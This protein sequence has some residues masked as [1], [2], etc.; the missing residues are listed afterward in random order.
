MNHSACR[1]FLAFTLVFALSVQ[2]FAQYKNG[3]EKERM[4]TSCKP[5]DDFYKYINGTWLKNTPIPD[6]EPR[7]GSFNILNDNNRKVLKEILEAAA[8]NKKSKPGSNEQMIGSMYA[9]CMD[10]AV[11]EKQGYKPIQPLLTRI[12]KINDV[13]NLPTEISYLHSVGVPALFN[14]GAQPDAKNSTTNLAGISQ[15][16]LT[17]PNKEYY[18]KTDEKSKEL[19]VKFVQHMTNM[20]KLIGEDEAKAKT[21][22][23]AVMRIQMKLADASLAPV[24]L[25]NPNNRYNKKTVKELS[26]LAPNF[27]FNAYF[28]GRGAIS[29][30][31]IN[32]A[33]PKFIGAVNGLLKEIPLEDWKT[34]LRW[35][36]V[37]SSANTL[38]SAFVNEAFNFN[39]KVLNGTKE[40]QPRW[41]RCVQ[42]VD[43]GLGDAL[44]QV[45][46]AKTFPPESKARM[47]KLIDNLVAAFRER[48]KTLD[49]MSETTKQ[50]ALTKLN[51]FGRKIGYPDKWKDYSTVKIDRKS[52]FENDLKVAQ[53]AIKRNLARINQPVDRSEWGM[54]PPTVN[55]YY[56][57]LM[58]EI[59]FPAGI[60]QPPFFNPEADDAIN[61]GAIG[62]VIG[63]ELSHGFDDQGSQFDEKGNLRM[64]WTP[65]DRKKF[66]A[67]ADCI[68]Q[69]FNSYKVEEGLYQNGKL[70]LGE[71][72]GDLGGLTMAYYAFKKSLEGK[73]RPANIDGFTPEQRFFIG[74]A[75]VW[76]TNARPEFERTQT[77]TDPH[78]LGRFRGNGPLSNFAPFAAAFNCQKGDPMVREG[79][80]LCVI[81]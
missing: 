13:N 30:N 75:Q 29:F 71:S 52:Y 41:R 14:F 79:E 45:Y 42:A 20:F 22:A 58:N 2:P 35:Q 39:G 43:Q 70:V 76:A 6:S 33:Q 19:R 7:W 21:S 28:V 12:A 23:D 47:D 51:A 8:A 60:L 55:A 54:T 78:P 66:E 67:R 69:Q 62:A 24:E 46:V 61:Y 63:H 56:T 18:T 25:R 50:A 64:W 32:V 9:S 44:G 40:Q 27:N 57:P 77:L 16:G 17:L 73:P 38:S 31:D 53:F 37:R 34:Y 48:I 65:E 72:I 3:F 11:I 26:E 59:A 15:G 10:E 68:V 74:W 36:V 80:K 1:L 81:W 49:W 4:D 5:C